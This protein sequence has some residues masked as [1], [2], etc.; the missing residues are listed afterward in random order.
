ML[1][2]VKVTVLCAASLPLRRVLVADGV[3]LLTFNQGFL[4]ISY[5]NEILL[6]KYHH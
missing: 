4:P 6:T 5:G 2:V 3:E 1:T